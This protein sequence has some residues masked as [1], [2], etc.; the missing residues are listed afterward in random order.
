LRQLTH[1][2]VTFGCY[3]VTGRKNPY[4]IYY[5]SEGSVVKGHMLSVFATQIPYINLNMK[6]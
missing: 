5:T 6:F 2:S 4:S 1:F 3:N